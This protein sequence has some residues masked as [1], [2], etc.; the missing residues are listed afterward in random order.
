MYGHP[1]IGGFLVQPNHEV[2]VSTAEVQV[3]G[4]PHPKPQTLNPKPKAKA[5]EARV[6]RMA[7]CIHSLTVLELPP[8]ALSQQDPERHWV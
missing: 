1:H 6:S 4:R 3:I 8:R 7:C 5:L 2:Q